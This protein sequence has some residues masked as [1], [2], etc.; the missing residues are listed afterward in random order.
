MNEELYSICLKT[1][2]DNKGW[3]F[4]LDAEVP[5]YT[6]KPTKVINLLLSK[7]KLFIYF[8]DGS[9]MVTG[10]DPQNVDL[11]YRPIKVKEDENR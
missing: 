3:Y 5:S 2:G 10:Y 4:T 8:E 1:Y 7:D 9:R 6:G 11:F